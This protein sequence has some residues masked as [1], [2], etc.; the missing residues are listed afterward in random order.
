MLSLITTFFGVLAKQWLYQ[1]ISVASGDPR[2]RALVRQARNLG[3]HAWHVPAFIGILPIILHISLALFLAGLILLLQKILTFLA[4]IMTVVVGTVYAAYF[5]SN[6]LPIIYPRCPYRTALTPK[7][8]QLYLALPTFP[9][10]HLVSSSD[11]VTDSGSTLPLPNNTPKH[12]VVL[13][14]T[15]QHKLKQWY[16]RLRSLH[17]AIVPPSAVKPVPWR[18]AERDDALNTK[19][20]LEGKAL[21]WLWK[22]S[23]NPTAKRVVLDAL[24]GL[25]PEQQEKYGESW[26]PDVMVSVEEEL[27]RACTHLCSAGLNPET[28]RRLEL[29]LRALKQIQ[30]FL[31]GALLENHAG[32][33]Q[34]PDGVMQVWKG[35][36]SGA[37]LRALLECGFY[38]LDEF[39]DPGRH[40]ESTLSRQ[41]RLR[42]P[43]EKWVSLIQK[44]HEQGP[45][46]PV[47]FFGSTVKILAILKK[48]AFFASPC[49]EDDSPYMSVHHPNETMCL[50]MYEYIVEYSG[51]EGITLVGEEGYRDNIRYILLRLLVTFASPEWTRA[52]KPAPKHRKKA[53]RI[54]LDCLLD[55]AEGEE[56]STNQVPLWTSR[57][58]SSLVEFTKTPLF[59]RSTSSGN[60]RDTPTIDPRIFEKTLGLFVGKRGLRAGSWTSIA[61]ARLNR[62]VLMPVYLSS[63][64]QLSQN[65]NHALLRLLVALT[66]K[67]SPVQTWKGMKVDTV[68]AVLECLLQNMNHSGRATSVAATVW[69]S[70]ETD[71]LVQFTKTRVFKDYF[72]TAGTSPARRQVF[73]KTFILI[74][75]Y[76]IPNDF[77]VS[78]PPFPKSIIKLSLRMYLH[79]APAGVRGLTDEE[80]N[81]NLD[82][83]FRAFDHHYKPLYKGISSAN[84][85]DELWKSWVGQVNGGLTGADQASQPVFLEHYIAGIPTQQERIS[86]RLSIGG[87]SW[88][89]QQVDYIHQ[90][91]I[92]YRICIILLIG[93][94]YDSRAILR[95]LEL[96]PDAESWYECLDSLA[97]L[98]YGHIPSAQEII[99]L[100]S[101][102]IS[103]N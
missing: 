85:I 103:S 82:F 102:H 14:S 11:E 20:A 26:E 40:L 37:Q 44:A 48:V 89:D 56:E 4:Y 38:Q 30:P 53:I 75:K 32:Q 63:A 100:L 62:I 93:I 33:I 2:S 16:I 94:G 19:G 6:V 59:D 28:E 73:L 83:L 3:L 96:K 76:C 13:G 35:S 31:E 65:I 15:Q 8:H 87:D 9:R 64:G 18:D 72:P 86:A 78:F 92:L 45:V 74:W 55:M 52:G 90:P 22:S 21:S 17:I 97:A 5:I 41:T 68:H 25:L 84:L 39:A 1:Y 54:A 69:S 57:E 99:P 36:S 50:A 29:Y 70:S 67:R 49:F 77:S 95:L 51:A 24:A 81:A 7:F 47:Q 34:L 91:K 71:L 88:V 43:A 60:R 98:P 80:R 10:V 23:Y 42:Y 27:R 46:R 79:G 101:S 58:I 61:V 66:F 12:Y